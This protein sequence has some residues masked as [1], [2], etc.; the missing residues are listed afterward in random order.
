M[1]SAAASQPHIL[2]AFASFLLVL[3]LLFFRSGFSKISC[4]NSSLLCH[5]N[6]SMSTFS[7]TE[8][9]KEKKKHA[10]QIS[11]G[12][13]YTS[14][15]RHNKKK[16][17]PVVQELSFTKTPKRLAAL[18]NTATRPGSALSTRPSSSRSLARSG[19]HAHVSAHTKQQHERATASTATTIQGR[20]QSRNP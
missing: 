16:Y 17:L 11:L 13:F 3:F 4:W 9:Q 19:L 8:K 1:V 6:S 2:R 5:D 15:S 12:S 10:A 14:W 7:L 18:P 20:G